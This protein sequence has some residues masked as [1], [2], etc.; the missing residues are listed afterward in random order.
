MSL[1][2]FDNHVLEVTVLR[3]HLNLYDILNDSRVCNELLCFPSLALLTDEL[4]AGKENDQWYI[5]CLDQI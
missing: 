3:V 2:L 4:C 1:E 5:L